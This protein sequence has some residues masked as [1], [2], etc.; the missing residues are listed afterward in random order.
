[1]TGDAYASQILSDPNNILG[2]EYLKALKELNSP[3]VP[4]TLKENFP[5]IMT[6]NFMTA[7]V[8]LLQSEKS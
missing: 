6:Q 4:F 7:P 8:L 2:I 1:M 5:D 3:I